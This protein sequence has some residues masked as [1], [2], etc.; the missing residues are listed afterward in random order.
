MDA[1][2]RVLAEPGFAKLGER[3]D[4]SKLFAARERYTEAMFEL[5]KAEYKA[6]KG[7]SLALADTYE[8]LS[9]IHASGGGSRTPAQLWLSYKYRIYHSARRAGINPSPHREHIDKA[10]KEMAA[11]VMQTRAFD[12]RAHMHYVAW[13]GDTLEDALKNRDTVADKGEEALQG[14]LDRTA[15]P[16]AAPEKFLPQHKEPTIDKMDSPGDALDDVVVP[17]M[18]PFAMAVAP[19]VRIIN[20]LTGGVAD[21]IEGGVEAVEDTVEGKPVKGVDNLADDVVDVPVKTAEQ[22][23][24]EV[25]GAGRVIGGNRPPRR[26]Q[27]DSAGY[28]DFNRE[29]RVEGMARNVPAE[30]AAAT[31][32]VR[33]FGRS[34]AGRGVSRAA[35]RH[36]Q[37]KVAAGAAAAAAVAA[38]GG[39]A[40]YKNRAALK[41]KYKQL[42]KKYGPKKAKA[43][44]KKEA[45]KGRKKTAGGK[46]RAPVKK[47]SKK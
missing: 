22:V 37:K 24:K 36:R 2:I 6:D 30:Q 27:A 29:R 31:A 7:R 28:P 32:R 19:F 42:R 45:K 33:A 26:V 10:S 34:E 1:R 46:K 5:A 20:T 18:K 9:L 3:Y 12:F 41:K 21:V 4:R 14:L 40:A 43:E 47:R 35:K 16:E 13:L 8:L 25:K 44:L 17:V 38:A 39:A 11:R 15:K 23:V